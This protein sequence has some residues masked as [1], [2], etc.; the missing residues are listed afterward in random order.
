MR[1]LTDVRNDRGDTLIEIIVAVAILGLA[2]VA[3]LGGLT[4]SVKVS[5]SHRK[6]ANSSGFARDY[7]EAI[8]HYVGKAANNYQKCATANVYSPSTVGF[9]VPAGYTA[10]QSA[11]LTWSTGQSQ[12]LACT[13]DPGVQRVTLTVASNDAR[14]TD[15][16]RVILRQPCSPSLP[17][18]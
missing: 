8:E 14:A 10:T 3:I 11:A 6:Q 16:L 15:T 1:A 18:S 7:A 5:D 9:T 4:L 12:W 13:T 17:C 2:A